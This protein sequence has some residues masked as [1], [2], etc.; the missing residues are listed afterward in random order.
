MSKRS[1]RIAVGTLSQPAGPQTVVQNKTGHRLRIAVKGE[2]AAVINRIKARKV[3]GMTL[4]TRQ[5]KVLTKAALRGALDSARDAA[6]AANPDME[7]KIRA[8][9]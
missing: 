9:Q 5:G 4:I 8:F 3:A 1:N 2:L 6:I 7:A